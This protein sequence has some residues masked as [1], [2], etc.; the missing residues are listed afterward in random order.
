VRRIETMLEKRVLRRATAVTTVSPAWTA[1]L[2]ARAD[3]PARVR[4][5]PNGFDEEDFAGIEASPPTDLFHLT[6]VG[7]LYASRNPAVLWDVL[8]EMKRAGRIP[9]LR[10]RIA[11]RLDAAVEEELRRRELLDITGIE[12]YVP[13]RR[14]V[15]AMVEAHLLLLTIEPF[16]AAAGMITGKLYEYLASG[17]PVLALGPE[18]GDAGALLAETGGGRLVGRDDREAI[19]REVE[20]HYDAW[21]AGTPRSGAEPG[22]IQPY[23]RSELTGRLAAILEEL[24]GG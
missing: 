9:R 3:D 6:Y 16:P 17:R 14:A 22:R 1:M 19:R 10:I 24:A 8:A 4:L 21:A 11:G 12:G 7:G 15:E 20:A 2:A 13:H 5:L 23:R 18:G